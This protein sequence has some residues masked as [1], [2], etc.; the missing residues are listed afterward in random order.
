MYIS[1]MYSLYSLYIPFVYD[2]RPGQG[3]PTGV[4]ALSLNG[5]MLHY[6]LYA[7]NE[8]MSYVSFCLRC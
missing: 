2:L 8:I 5:L 7:M 1:H 6:M 3:Y 4:M